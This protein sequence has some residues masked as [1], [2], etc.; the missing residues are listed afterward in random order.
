MVERLRDVLDDDVPIAIT[1]YNLVAFG[2]G[3][4]DQSMIRAVNALYLADS[5]GQMALAGVK[6]AAQWNLANGVMASGTDYGLIEADGFAP[7]P[8]YVAMRAWSSLGPTLVSSTGEVRDV[9][10]Y[11]TRADDGALRILAV[12]TGTTDRRL[13]IGFDTPEGEISGTLTAT[14]AD[15]IDATDMTVEA[16]ETLEQTAGGLVAVLPPNSVSVLEVTGA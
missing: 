16:P 14:W 6:V 7:R 12:H 11:P 8:Q 4:T 15:D 13:S 9:R 1:E 5:I 2:D 10:V 3:D